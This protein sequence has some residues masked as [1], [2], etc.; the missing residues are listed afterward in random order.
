MNLYRSFFLL[1]LIITSKL[2]MAYT[3]DTDEINYIYHPYSDFYS[4]NFLG[5]DTAGRGYSG[6]ANIG[7]IE[8]TLIN[9][10]SLQIENKIQFYYEYGSKKKM[11]YLKEY[12]NNSEL[13]QYKKG[14]FL[15]LAYKISDYFQAG[16]FYG[17]KYSIKTYFGTLYIL[18]Y[19]YQPIDSLQSYFKKKCSTLN[20]PISYQHSDNFR[21]GASINFEIYESEEPVILFDYYGNYEI[22]KGKADF[23]KI[24]TTIGFILSLHKYIT[25]GTS[26][27][28]STKTNVIEDVKWYKVKYKAN[29]FPWELRTGLM[30]SS[31]NI[32]LN[33][34]VDFQHVHTSDYHDLKNRNDFF[35]GAEYKLKKYI[36][37]LGYMTQ[38]EYRDLSLKINDETDLWLDDKPHR[39]HFLTL[40]GSCEWKSLK[41]SLAYMDSKILSP[42]EEDQK[43]FK[44]SITF[45]PTK[46]TTKK[47]ELHN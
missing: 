41:F 16:L 20:V 24:R 44:L 21:I 10:A 11:D 34:F 28:S 38:N 31:P 40:G 15:G 45:K 32:P 2:L 14:I 17:N 1:M 33:L 25:F 46:M 29:I 22:H 13:S 37:R 47:K 8:A 4:E 12:Y 26:F 18:D 42:N 43:Y 30:Y 23:V 5:V 39:R 7:G 19:N 35:V 27:L 3:I 9:P 36:F 6:V